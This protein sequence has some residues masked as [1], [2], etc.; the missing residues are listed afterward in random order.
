MGEIT[1]LLNQLSRNPWPI[2]LICWKKH[3]GSDRHAIFQ[4]YPMNFPGNLHFEWLNSTKSTINWP[5]FLIRSRNH[6]EITMEITRHEITK[7]TATRSF[8][9]FHPRRAN[10]CSRARPAMPCSSSPVRGGRATAWWLQPRPSRGNA[11]VAG[12]GYDQWPMGTSW[13]FSLDFIVISMGIHQP[14]WGYE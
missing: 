11:K 4:I 9:T 7:I 14:K 3:Y 5:F 13:G 2:P 10:V 8:P 6:H 12:W 1:Q